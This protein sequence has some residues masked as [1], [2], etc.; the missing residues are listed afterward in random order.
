MDPFSLATGVV[1]LVTV[2]LQLV[3]GAL[4]MID[5]TVAA[6]NEAADELK[7]LQDDLEDLEA[8]MNDI[9][10]TLQVL[11]SNTKDRA[12]KKLLR[13]YASMVYLY[14]CA[15]TNVSF[16]EHSNTAIAKLCTALDETF[17]LLARLTDQIK[18]QESRLHSLA[19]PDD[20]RSLAFVRAILKHNLAPSK[21]SHL[22]KSLRDMRAEIQMCLRKLET[23]F[24]HPWRLYTAMSNGLARVATNE[25]TFSTSTTLTTRIRLV[26]W[27]KDREGLWGISRLRNGVMTVSIV[28]VIWNIT[29]LSKSVSFWNSF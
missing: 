25:T 6:H 22:V 4:G 14:L 16:S 24:Q 21:T 23:A 5:T 9:H 12:F 3:T 1:G 2:A 7:K 26:G 27:L 15:V 19:L 18:A 10:A 11:A 28:V 20:T 13:K 29:H 17:V 8:Q